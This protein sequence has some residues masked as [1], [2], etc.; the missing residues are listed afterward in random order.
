MKTN[1]ELFLDKIV[2]QLSAEA[3][4][5]AFKTSSDF[6]NRIRNLINEMGGYEGNLVDLKPHPHIFPDIPLAV[7]GI[8]VKFTEKDTWRSV[9]NSIFES[10]RDNY[11]ENIY[12]IFGKMGGVPEVKW[13]KYEE[14]VMH[15]RTSHVPRFE[16]EI[17]ASEPIFVQFGISYS[18]FH[19]LDIH[20]KMEFVRTYA[21]SRLKQGEKLWWLEN[22]EDDPHTLPLQARLYTSL[23]VAEK[24]QY[25]AEAALL[26]PEI[27]KGSR[28]RNKYDNAVLYLLTYRGVLC[29][30]ARDLFTAGSVAGKARGG[31]YIERSLKNI[32]QEIIEA[33]NTLEDA[34]FEEYWGHV[35]DKKDRILEWLKMA[36][37][38]CVD[39]KPS[40][41]LFQDQ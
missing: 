10:T 3:K 18:E 22:N 16:L 7:E 37:D 38:M 12:V 36:D 26:C 39:W 32:E 23:D 30:Q 9:A 25:R 28:T 24:K 41:S 29:H 19:K 34:L 20:E 2:T 17:G 14:C 35:P 13:Q 11:V 15:V 21:R 6:E 33:S 5:K 27:V 1:F 8:E 4:A 31:I 40:Q